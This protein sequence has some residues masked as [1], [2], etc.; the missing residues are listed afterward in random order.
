MAI[1]IA[2][3]DKSTGKKVGQGSIIPVKFLLNKTDNLKERVIFSRPAKFQGL[4]LFGLPLIPDGR[5]NIIFFKRQ[6]QTSIISTGIRSLWIGNNIS[7]KRI[8]FEKEEDRPVI[9]NHS[10]SCF[11]HSD[12]IENDHLLCYSKN[13]LF[14]SLLSV[15]PKVVIS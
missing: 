13:N 15:S 6:G 10:V 7:Y 14:Q 12:E 4:T 1:I 9:R 2:L 8:I 5:N 3:L 11:H